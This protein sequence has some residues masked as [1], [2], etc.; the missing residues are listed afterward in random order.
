MAK[1]RTSYKRASRL[2]AFGLSVC[3]TTQFLFITSVALGAEDDTSAPAT[4]DTLTVRQTYLEGADA[5]VL[6][7]AITQGGQKYVRAGEVTMSTDTDYVR[8]LEHFTATRFAEVPPEDRENLFAYFPPRVAIDEGDFA[9]E[10]ALDASQ[11]FLVTERYEE[12]SGQVD[13]TIVFEGLADNNVDRIPPAQDFSVRS[14]EAP[15]ATQIKTL[16]VVHVDIVPVAI[17]SLGLPSAYSATVTYRGQEEYLVLHHYDVVANYAGDIVSSKEQFVQE[18]TYLPV[19]ETAPFVSLSE[20]TMPLAG[21]L[22]QATVTILAAGALV[23]VVYF[24]VVYL[25]AFKIGSRTEDGHYKIIRRVALKRTKDTYSVHI[26][27]DIVLSYDSGI[28][29]VLPARYQYQKRNIVVHQGDALIYS[30]KVLAEIPLVNAQHIYEGY[31][32]KAAGTTVYE[33]VTS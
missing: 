14:A 20:P 26:P 16:K 12:F 22:A 5:P 13:R 3:I 30:G 2:W 4:G 31:V 25:R 11:P 24:F 27:A 17:D 1:Q 29:G 33:P 10:I 23:V 8:P 21:P 9:G 6:P 7:V 19:Y 15:D 32:A 28:V 18:V